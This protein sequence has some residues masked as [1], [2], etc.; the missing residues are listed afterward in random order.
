MNFKLSGMNHPRKNDCPEIS[1]FQPDTEFSY[2][3]CKFWMEAAN[4]WL[5]SDAGS[6][7]GSWHPKWSFQKTVA[8]K[9]EK[10]KM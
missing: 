10:C 8:I 6:Q 4:Q 7:T 5:Y 2:L 9:D 3:F 1:V